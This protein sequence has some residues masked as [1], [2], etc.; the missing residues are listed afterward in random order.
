[1]NKPFLASAL[2]LSSVRYTVHD[3]M[4]FI[5]CTIRGEYLGDQV[6]LHMNHRARR[7]VGL[8]PTGRC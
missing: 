3:I 4:T 1:M 2:C 6:K 7:H 5:M 8:W